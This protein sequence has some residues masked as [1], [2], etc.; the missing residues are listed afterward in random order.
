M[1]AYNRFEDTLAAR[2][3]SS[4]GTSLINFHKTAVPDNIRYY[5][6]RQS[7]PLASILAHGL[8]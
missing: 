8:S 4:E 3:Q 1:C 6:R 7:A 5:D 2:L